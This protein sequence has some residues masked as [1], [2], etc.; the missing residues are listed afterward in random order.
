MNPLVRPQLI[1]S[2]A[3]LLLA[4]VLAVPVR[5]ALPEPVV[6]YTFDDVANGGIAADTGAAPTTNGV[7]NGQ[8]TRTALGQTPSGTGYALNVNF[9]GETNYLVT[10]NAD[11]LNT[12]S[13]MTM[14]AWL[15]LRGTPAMNDRILSKLSTFAGYDFK[16]ANASAN[17]FP[18]L[19]INQTSSRDAS[20]AVNASNRWVF[21]AVTY[22]ATITNSAIRFYAGSSNEVVYQLSSHD[23]PTF[24]GGDTI[25]SNA[26]SLRIGSTPAST[27]DRTPPAWLDDVRVYGQVLS[28]LELEQVRQEEVPWVGAPGLLNQ[29]VSTNVLA[30]SPV[31]F[32]VTAIPPAP[33]PTYQWRVNG[34][35]I[36]GATNTTYSIPAAA[37]ELGAGYDVVVTGA[38]GAVTSS[39]ALLTVTTLFQTP[40]MTNVLTL[41]PPQSNGPVVYLN[42]S[43]NRERGMTFNPATGRLI[44]VSRT[45]TFSTPTAAVLDPLTGG[46]LGSLDQSALL[47]GGF[48]NVFLLNKIGAAADG[49]LFAANMTFDPSSVAFALYRWADESQ[50]QTVAFT[51]DPGA[52]GHPNLRWG[53]TLAVRGSGTGTQILL[54]AAGYT[55][56]VSNPALSNNANVVSILSTADGVTFTNVAVLVTNAP[57]GGNGPFGFANNGLAWGAGNTFFAKAQSNALV[58]VAFDPSTGLGG[59][60]ETYSLAAVPAT[61]G[62]I[63]FNSGL[64]LFAALDIFNLRIS[65]GYDTIRLYNFSGGGAAP[66]LIDQELSG[67]NII[68]DPLGGAGSV[69]FGQIGGTNYLFVLDTGNGVRT[70]AINTAYSGLSGPFSITA[71]NPLGGGQ[72]ALMWQSAAGRTYQA[73]SRDSLTGGAWTPVG[74]P[75]VATG[76]SSSVTN[77]P[78]P[79]TSVN[80][81]YYRVRGY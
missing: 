7:F 71:I 56:F 50:P 77:L 57:V 6:R 49:A 32:S 9:P 67:F 52:P 11:K 64:N 29:P 3:G 59:V 34:T 2:S 1:A 20:V 42:T 58:K 78:V 54:A 60:T 33:A 46:Y 41:L 47:N 13:N 15:N 44:V 40:V 23:K 4:L 48:N 19:T 24:F 27:A 12:F 74:A 68:N 30:G 17:I 79:G 22:D 51:G 31:T 10:G 28:A 38:G 73:E 14:T 18:G 39:V 63:A 65:R 66:V 72:T 43:G 25:L 35:P 61:A 76:A 81:R 26:A 8:A 55:N 5:A 16:I 75:V 62:P 53:D 37:P 80:Q 36:P 45:G 21:L 70:F 69:E